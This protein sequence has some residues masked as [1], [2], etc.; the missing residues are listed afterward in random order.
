MTHPPRLVEAL[1]ETGLERG[2]SL[3]LRGIRSAGVGE[4]ISY[5][6]LRERVERAAAAIAARGAHV[7]LLS[8]VNSLELVTSLLGALHAGARVLLLPAD[9]PAAALGAAARAAGAELAI[10]RDGDARFEALPLPVVRDTEFAA[11]AASRCEPL[12]EPA[13]ILLPTSGTTGASKIVVRS[14]PGIL[15]LARSSARV[16]G[17]A[18]GD[19]SALA[20]PVCHSYGVDQLVGALA[21]GACVDLH[22]GFSLGALRR[23]FREDGVSVFPGVPVMLDALS[24]G[25]RFEAPELRCVLS[26]G[27]PLARRVYERFLAVS[28]IAIGQFY[29]ASE[30][31][32]VSYNNPASSEFDPMDVGAPF[33][34]AV[35]RVLPYDADDPALELPPGAEGLIAV[36]G[37]TLMDGYLA[38]PSPLRGGFFVTGDLGVRSDRGALRITGRSA[39]VIDVGGRKVN[40]AEVERVL[41]LH[42]SVREAV[43]LPGRGTDTYARLN[44][45][46]VPEPGACPDEAELRRFVRELLPPH[47]VPRRIELCPDPPRS[48]SGKIQ[49][50][51]LLAARPTS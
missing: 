43:V 37:P 16:F 10:A 46:V 32:S 39:F 22:E 4:C 29:G 50:A 21:A 17:L 33:G 23:S 15:T 41:A 13:A 2:D 12:S 5:G 25:D 47:M 1:L 20:I 19:R 40:P 27:S 44:A 51:Q 45:L 26:S 38:H 35:I 49:R 31:G 14:L 6:E 18:R 28:Q 24:R 9:L 36:S 7:V 34:G 8:S 42:P 30:F 11:T 3:A 48:A